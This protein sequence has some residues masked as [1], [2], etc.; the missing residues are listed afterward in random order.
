M[1]KGT[2]VRSKETGWKRRGA[3]SSR[4]DRSQN[5]RANMS[6]PV[7]TRKKATRRRQPWRECRTEY[8]E[9]TGKTE[10]PTR[11]PLVLL[12]GGRS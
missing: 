7:K 4:V 10:P 1:T 9:Q 2:K 12:Q 11:A 5:Y 3:T 6:E 8:L